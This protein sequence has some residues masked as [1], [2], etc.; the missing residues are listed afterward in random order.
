MSGLL[1][2]VKDVFW[3][4]IS[5]LV[6]LIIAFLILRVLGRIGQGNIIGQGVNA[7][8]RAATPPTT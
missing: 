8:N 5:V 2:T 7:V 1:N 3:A 4:A 6:L